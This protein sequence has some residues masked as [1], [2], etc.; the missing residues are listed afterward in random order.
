MTTKLRWML[1]CGLLLSCRRESDATNPP[2]DDGPKNGVPDD[3]VAVVDGVA[4]PRDAFDEALVK[5]VSGGPASRD[6][7]G[8][9]QRLLLALVARELVRTELAASGKDDA[10]I[11]R[12][13]VEVQNTLARLERYREPGAAPPAW[14]ARPPL[15]E[16][17][18]ARASVLTV[19]K[20][21]FTVDE[22]ELAAEY[23]R[24]KAGWTAD[25]PWMHV[26]AITVRYD[27]G[28]G[29]PACDDYLAK[30]RRCTTKFPKSTQPTMIADLERT[31]GEWRREAADPAKHAEL[32]T[33]CEGVA[34]TTTK[35]TESMACDWTSDV[36]PNDPGG[37][38][39]R[40]KAAKERA[41]AV[42]D[43]L[44]AGVE[45]EVVAAELGSDVGG[46]TVVHAGQV[47][48][49]VAKAIAKLK[50]GALGKQPIDDGDAF[51]VVKLIE[52]WP[53][54][55]I[56]MEAR[57][58]ELEERAKLRKFDAAFAA[59]PQTLAAA[60]EVELHPSF[61]PLFDAPK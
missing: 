15:E 13:A 47:G 50:P 20:G 38:N 24:H 45:A 27:D 18:L 23:E 2:V 30:Y 35:E 54:G 28:V 26:V 19:Q 31:A 10:E 21:A 33:K 58:A 61:E 53:A 9:R 37:V 46:D 36:S 55:T 40:K 49:P 6:D 3:A 25:Q 34:A 60:H 41:K 59:L 32:A 44:A 43:K 14:A 12:S 16:V 56:P 39:D 8:L 48:K 22:A 57:R 4:I 17:D 7:K 51:V 11:T 29:V 52:K 5:M 42:R 1:A